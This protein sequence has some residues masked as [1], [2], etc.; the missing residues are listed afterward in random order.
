MSEDRSVLRQSLFPALLE[1]AKYNAARQNPSLGLMK[2]VKSSYGQGSN[3][4]PL[5]KSVWPFLLYLALRKVSPGMGQLNPMISLISKVLLKATWQLSVWISKSGLQ[6]SPAILEL[7]PGR[8]A[9]SLGDQVIGVMGQIHPVLAKSYDLMK[10]A[11][12]L[13]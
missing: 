12:S 4:Q 10:P 9:W 1:I 13:N 6:A 7:H 11:S 2:Q 5:N 8:T 3:V